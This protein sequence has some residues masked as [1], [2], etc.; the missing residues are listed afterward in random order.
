MSSF[1]AA[2]GLDAPVEVVNAREVE[3]LAKLGVVFYAINVAVGLSVSMPGFSNRIAHGL[4]G[5][6]PFGAISLVGVRS[7]EEAAAARRSG[8]DALLVKAELLQSYGKDVQALGN[9]LQYAV[10]LDD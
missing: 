1:S 4:L 7:L 9:A 3:Q 6:L 8:A 5:E 10:T 2:L